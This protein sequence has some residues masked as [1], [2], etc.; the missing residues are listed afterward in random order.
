[1]QPLPGSRCGETGNEAQIPQ[2]MEAK[3]LPPAVRSDALDKGVPAK[4]LPNFET[5]CWLERSQYVASRS[6]PRK[7][8]IERHPFDRDRQGA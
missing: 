7:S 5:A 4:A 2:M 6:N 1:M 3:G 8:E